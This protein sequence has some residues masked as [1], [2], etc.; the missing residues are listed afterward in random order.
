[1]ATTYIEEY[2]VKLGAVVDA[3]GMSRFN[4]ALRDATSVSEISAASIGRAFFKAQSEI[5]GGFLSI[6][7]AALGLVD[8]V[9]MADQQFRLLSVKMFM[10]KEDTRALT[11]A[12]DALGASLG[13]ITWDPTGELGR[14]MHQLVEDQRAMAPDGD[15]D[16]QMEKIR[17]IRFQFTRMEVEAQYVGM[18]VVETF[19][20]SLGLGP[21]VLLAKLTNLN[22]WVTH[23]VPE[24]ADKIV[25]LFGP[26]WKDIEMVGHAT[27]TALGAASVAFTNLIG[28][29]TGD[30]S[31]MGT[32]FDIEKLAGAV[33]HVVHGFAVFATA[34]ANVEEMLAHLVSG[35]ALLLHMD[36]SGAGTEFAAAFSKINAK[37]LGLGAGAAVGVGAGMLTGGETGAALGSVVGPVGTAIGGT[38]G[39]ALGG[40]AAALP[41]GFL[42]SNISERVF[43]G[44]TLAAVG[45]VQTDVRA[46]VDRYA[47]RN[48]VDPALAHA[49][50]QTES[51]E[52]QFTPSGGLVRP[53]TSSATGAFQLTNAT[54]RALNVNSADTEQN[55]RGG[56]EL[57]AHLLSKYHDQ[58]TAVAAYH[59]GETKMDA[60]LAG[61]ATLSPEAR[62]EVAAV[63][64]RTGQTGDVHVGGITIHIAKPNA[65]NEDVGRVVEARLRDVQNKR[66]QR[67]LA[68][69]QDQSYSY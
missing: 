21:D 42:G 39:A 23:H 68:E 56:V 19:F 67:N 59:E 49:L 51:G 28:L 61:R 41:A 55:V 16:R 10:S 34:I 38:V 33:T 63:M 26:V 43:G 69:F 36:F 48:G 5:T 4:Q 27:A 46:L 14:R 7:A 32:T 17:D 30:A 40:A 18:Q 24:I 37:T 50:S 31:I 25:H 54:A 11:V 62:H 6:G 29:L 45:R 9:A 12:T 64:G 1:M 65:T 13:E 66:V 53:A 58:A 47:A 15:F 3:D 8:K 35:L 20:K 60:I 22:D 52:R 57:L 44:S 2:L